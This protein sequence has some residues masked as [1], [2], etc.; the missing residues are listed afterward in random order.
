MEHSA[1]CHEYLQVWTSEKQD[2][3]ILRGFAYVLEVVQQEEQFSVPQVI[4]QFLGDQTICRMTESEGVGD[5]AENQ[6]V[7]SHGRERNGHG[8]IGEEWLKPLCN[9]E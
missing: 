7:F 1:A 9:L 4:R 3:N 6:R 5:R 8:A 2:G